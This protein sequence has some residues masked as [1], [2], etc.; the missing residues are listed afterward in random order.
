[1]DHFVGEFALVIL[2]L[3][4]GEL[5]CARDPMGDRTLFYSCKGTRLVVASEAWAVAGADGA[6][7]D[8][9]EEAV[10]NYFAYKSLG[11]GQ[12]LFTKVTELLP[13]HALHVNELGERQ[14]SYWQPDFS[15][16]LPTRSEQECAEE[17]RSVLEE[18]VRSR[19]RSISPVGVLMSGGLDS[20]SVACLAARILK[21]QA[22]TTIS[23]VF[24]ELTECDERSYI[25]TVKEMWGIRSIQIP[26]DDAWAFKKSPN[27]P[28]NPNCPAGN[29]FPV[30]KARAYECAQQKGLRVILT[31]GAADQI[32]QGGI[33]WL[34][35]TLRAGKFLE[36]SR[37]LSQ[38]RRVG[39]WHW[40]LRE[41]SL[42]RTGRRLLKALPG[43]KYL[44][45]KPGK[46]ITPAWLTPLAIEYILRDKKS[47]FS[48]FERHSSMLALEEAQGIS[49]EIFYSSHFD[50]EQRHPYRDRRL[51]E[52]IL[53]LPTFFLNSHGIH[54]YILRI[55]M[56]GILP[57]AI[58]TR[59]GKTDFNALFFRGIER[60]NPL[61]QACFQ[62][63]AAA[64]HRYIRSDWQMQMIANQIGSE[65]LLPWMCISYENWY[66]LVTSQ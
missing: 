3:R 48:T 40:I 51:I 11:D 49:S 45:R 53:A 2:D 65:R 62:D 59:D 12:T 44:R 16:H 33:D 22:L 28:V 18:S 19:L 38:M 10:A 14:W 35:D 63:P 8:V 4:R 32:F 64:W 46:P 30:L 20:A 60:E 17:F 50:V 15:I 7:P 58:R 41:G 56:S 54:K 21:P 39:G 6:T 26:C 31:G 24:D 42:Q 13:A 27:W 9:N 25:D 29:P 52:F 1:L 43:K 5:I 34:F 55:A 66:K 37:E 23:Y 57:D 36:A 61:S 47:P